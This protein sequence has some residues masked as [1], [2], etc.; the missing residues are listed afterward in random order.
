MRFLHIHIH[1]MH[2]GLKLM[3]TAILIDCSC[4]TSGMSDCSDFSVRLLALFVNAKVLYDLE[5]VRGTMGLVASYKHPV[6]LLKP[7]IT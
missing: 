3:P 1:A 6:D 2:Y 5:T 4:S 7:T